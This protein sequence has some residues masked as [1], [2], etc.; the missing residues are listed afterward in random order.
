MVMGTLFIFSRKA[1]S[2]IDSGAKHSFISYAFTTYVD[3]MSELLDSDLVV[4]T[5]VG[6]SLLANSVYKECSIRVN[7]RELKANLIPLDIH[8]FDVI[9]GMDFLAVNHASVDCF[10][11]EVVFEGQESLKLFL[12]VNGEYYLHVSYL[13]LIQEDCL[14]KVVKLIW[15]M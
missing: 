14:E 15:L 10:R 7:D 2:L 1:R 3:H 11:K 9:L 8:D 6:D 13:H 4:A 5:P 12:V